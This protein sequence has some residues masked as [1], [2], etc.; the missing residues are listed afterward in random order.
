VK[1]FVL[2][3]VAVAALACLDPEDQRPG[4]RLSGEVV[5]DPVEDWSFTDAHR[6]IF[7]ETHAPWLV[8]HSVTIACA[9]IDGRLYIGARKPEGKR[10]VANVARD[11]EVRLAIGDKVYEGQLE[12]VEDPSEQETVYLGFASKY[13]REI[14]PP[15]ERPLRWYWRVLPRG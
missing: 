13:G 12:R 8:P 4:L 14:E 10:W 5:T 2:S 3:L 1:L 7:V 15:A 9:A 6:E 11:P